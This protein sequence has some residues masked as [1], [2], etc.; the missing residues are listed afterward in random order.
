MRTD[1]VANTYGL[2]KS[3]RY[4]YRDGHTHCHRNGCGELDAQ[5]D[6]YTA[7]GTVTEASSDRSA[8][9]IK[10]LVTGKISSLRSP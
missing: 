5:T 6:T 8:E 10:I 3:D 7:P 2:T 1:P 9:T 4:C